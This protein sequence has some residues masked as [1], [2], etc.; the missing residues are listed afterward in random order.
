MAA[1]RAD[2]SGSGE[3]LESLSTCWSEQKVRNGDSLFFHGFSTVL[4]GIFTL[5]ASKIA[6]FNM[7]VFLISC[8][9][10]SNKRQ[11][12][13]SKGYWTWQNYVLIYLTPSIANVY[14]NF[15]SAYLVM[16]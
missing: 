15:L 13:E 1:T 9:P 2:A 12:H 7:H 5:I 6:T 14:H 10:S 3:Q 4:L 16:K 11:V 8:S